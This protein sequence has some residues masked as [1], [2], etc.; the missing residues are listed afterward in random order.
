[1]EQTPQGR[2]EENR[3]RAHSQ[4]V[5]A[6]LMQTTGEDIDTKIADII[7]QIVQQVQ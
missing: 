7:R 2:E 5:Q 1:M 6:K 3:I 4:G